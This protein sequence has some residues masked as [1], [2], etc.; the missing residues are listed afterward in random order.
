MALP[1]HLALEIVTPDRAIVHD[2]VDEVQV[3]GSE[4]YFG[5]LPGHTPLLS[6]LQVGQLWYRKGAE[7]FY[8]SIAFGLAEV[9]P[10]RVVD[11]RADRRAR[12]GDRRGPRAGGASAR[13]AAAGVAPARPGSRSRPRRPDEGPDPAERGNPGPHPRIGQ[14]G[15]AAV[16]LR[17]PPTSAFAARST[18]TATARARISGCSPSPTASA[19]TT[20]ARSRRTPPID[21]IAAG[22][23]RDARLDGTLALAVRLP[24][25]ARRRRQPA[26]LGAAPGEPPPAGRG[27]RGAR[28]GRGWRRRSPR[29]SSSRTR[30]ACATRSAARRSATSATAA[31]TAGGRTG[32]IA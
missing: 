7:K 24:A 1:A 14:T 26:E 6:M 16:L 27:R 2:Q 22:D 25:A 8:L 29:C 28:P 12:R 13:R 11:P 17:P 19:A 15:H 3:P 5:V 30:R 18:R 32:S 23:R 9:L 20:P 10:D 21:A 31:S 4:G